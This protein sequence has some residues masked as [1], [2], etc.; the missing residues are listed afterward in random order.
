MSVKHKLFIPHINSRMVAI[1]R[2]LGRLDLVIDSDF[3]H[4]LVMCVYF[5]TL[6]YPYFLYCVISSGTLV[7]RPNILKLKK[8]IKYCTSVY[9]HGM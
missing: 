7:L 6:V 8:T 9:V 2:L 1:N 4:Y 3:T 5:L